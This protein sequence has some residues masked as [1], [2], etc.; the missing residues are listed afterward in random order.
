[1]HPFIASSNGNPIITNYLKYMYEN[2]E[3][4]SEIEIVVKCICWQEGVFCLQR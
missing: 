1:M 3:R 2:T 4:L